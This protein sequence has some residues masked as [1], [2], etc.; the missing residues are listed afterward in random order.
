MERRFQL[1]A[2]RSTRRRI[3]GRHLP[4]IIEVSIHLWRARKLSTMNARFLGERYERFV[5][6]FLAVFRYDAFRLFVCAVVALIAVILLIAG[7]RYDCTLLRDL[8][9]NV[10]AAAVAVAVIDA[11]YSVR[12][13][14]REALSIAT[15]LLL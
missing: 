15:E 1:R 11:L 7:S 6:V 10:L 13:I 9:V 3:L 2:M 4:D 5:P 8:G 14:Q 12:A